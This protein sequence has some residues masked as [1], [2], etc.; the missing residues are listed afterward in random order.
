MFNN[1]ILK[2][3]ENIGNYMIL[4]FLLQA[5]EQLKKA[6]EIKKPDVLKEEEEEWQTVS[7]FLNLLLNTQI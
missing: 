7:L 3:F 5:E 2:S 4:L 1:L 6:K